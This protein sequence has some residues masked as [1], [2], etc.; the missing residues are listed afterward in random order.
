MTT[1]LFAHGLESGPHG[2]KVRLLTEAGF[3]VVADRMPC[4]TPAVLQDPV[5]LAAA[6]AAIAAAVLLVARLGGVLGLAVAVFVAAV[7]APNARAALAR[8]VLRRSVA[9]Q[10][11]ALAR[12]RVDVVVGSSFGGAVA[13]ELLR[14]GAWTGP[15]VLLC[16]AH[17]LVAHRARRVPPS[18][19]VLSPEQTAHVVVVHGRADAVVPIAH[20]EEL[21]AGTA[22][23]LIVV[24]DDHRLTATATADNLA[25]WIALT[26]G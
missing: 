14:S 10:R 5:V 24:D 15:T 20:S 21:V 9:V 3:T 26:R 25:G 1:V 13:L 19:R 6:A 22:A 7:T 23:R 8:R 2:R 12:H 4:G 16:P 11:R 18:L 17:C